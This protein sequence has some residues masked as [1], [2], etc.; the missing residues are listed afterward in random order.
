MK[1]PIFGNYYPAPVPG[2]RG[3]GVI[4]DLR[5]GSGGKPLAEIDGATREEFETRLQAEID[6]AERGEAD[7]DLARYLR[8]RLAKNLQIDEWQRGE[9]IALAIKL[10]RGEA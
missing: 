4:F 3:S 7:K 10:E 9:L 6:K 1:S 2:T 5:R 8:K